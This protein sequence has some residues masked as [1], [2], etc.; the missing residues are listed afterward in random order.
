M[1]RKELLNFCNESGIRTEFLDEAK[2]NGVNRADAI[3]KEIDA[4]IKMLDGLRKIICDSYALNGAYFWEPGNKDKR[5]R[6]EW[7]FNNNAIE[8][9]EGGHS[10]SAGIRVN[11]SCRNVYVDRNFYRDD[12][13]TTLTSIK[14]SYNR[15]LKNLYVDGVIEP[16]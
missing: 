12:A 15:M 1:N 4:R 2:A 8:W 6:I 9:Q 10:Y 13:K 7:R 14:N 11:C 5:K 16:I 3:K